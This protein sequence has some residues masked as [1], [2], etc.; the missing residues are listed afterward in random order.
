MLGA[1]SEGDLRV[2]REQTRIKRAVQSALHRDLVEIDARDSATAADL[3]DGLSRFRP[4]V[5][6][7][8]GHGNAD[9]IEFEDEVDAP[10]QGVVVSAE[11]FAHAV[12]AVDEPPLLVVL[13]AC[14][15]A[16]QAERL[17]GSVAPFAIGMAAEIA[18][19]DAITYAARFYAAITDGQ[20]ILA[21]H[22][23]ARSELELAG[24]PAHELPTLAHADGVDPADGVLVLPPARARV[25]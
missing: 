23:L 19:T 13:N 4:H 17:A 7:F 18:D 1:S 14:D 9:L 22:E 3:L 11:A 24:L 15:S 5:V 21:A 20:S 16:T 12:N 25:G 10:H 6:H 8:S 2:A